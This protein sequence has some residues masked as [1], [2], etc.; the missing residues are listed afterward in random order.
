MS[1]LFQGLELGKRALLTHQ[2]SLQTISH[3][4]ANVDTEGYTRQRVITTTTTPDTSANYSVGTGVTATDIRQVKDLFLGDQY[5]QENKSLGQWSYKEK[6]LSQ[7]EA[8]YSEPADD[9]LSDRLNEFWSAWS[10]LAANPDSSS[11]RTEILSQANTLINSFHDMS[12]Q[13][14]RLQSS[15]DSDLVA[16][17]SEIN[18]MLSDIASLN[19]EIKVAEVGGVDA[20]DLRDARDLV[21]DELSGYLDVN[22]HESSNGDMIVYVGSMAIVDGNEPHYIEAQTENVDGNPRHI[23][24]WE[25]TD[26]EV[27]NTNGKLKGIIDSRDD[28]IP[29]QLEELN[30]LAEAVVTQV[31]ALH[32]TG[33][34]SSGQTAVSF[35]DPNYTNAS[36]IRINTAITLDESLIMSGT[37]GEE[38]DN[39]VALEIADLA[40]ARVLDNGASSISDYYNSMI[41]SLGVMT[42][43]AQS[44]TS[45]YELLVNQVE[46]ARQSVEG[47]S[48]DEEMTNLVKFQ[49]AYDAAARVITT[50]DE[51]LDTVI[52]GMGIVG[53]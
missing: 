40:D 27:R 20:N 47:V 43:E 42:Y 26:I 6:T 38:G 21:I 36:D 33:T 31:N 2:V 37:S 8:L 41:G 25:G 39:R 10:D 14:T 53:R 29:E 50:M 48:L 15:I 4:I 1:G 34:A 19:H 44:F 16:T 11:V 51:A 32:E 3:N 35:F 30:L 28:I 23:L 5:R 7:I 22:T 9:T 17:V 45:N 12:S 13:L 46:N 49:H 18:L 52:S 24:V